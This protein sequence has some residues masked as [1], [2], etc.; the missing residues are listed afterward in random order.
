MTLFLCD[1]FLLLFFPMFPICFLYYKAC[2]WNIGLLQVLNISKL[3]H[4]LES[5]HS[6]F[7]MQSF[8][9]LLLYK[10]LVLKM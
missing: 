7:Y 2:S 9:V 3:H 10:F 1:Y 5:N 6:T 4:M 8:L